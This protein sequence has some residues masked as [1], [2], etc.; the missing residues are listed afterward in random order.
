MRSFFRGAVHARLSP[1]APASA[2]SAAPSCCGAP[3]NVNTFAQVPLLNRSQLVT[4]WRELLPPMRDRRRAPHPARRQAA[5]H[6]P[7]RGRAC[8]R[9]A[10][11]RSSSSRTSAWSPRPR[12]ARCWPSPPIA[13]PASRSP[14][15][16]SA[17]CASRRPLRRGATGA[18]GV[19][20]ARFERSVERRRDSVAHCGEQTT[21]T[22]P[23][24]WY[25]H[26][27]PREL[28]GYVYTDKPIY[29]P[30]HTVHIKAFL[31]WRRTGRCCRSTPRTSSSAS[32]TSPTR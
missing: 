20:N 29:R 27:P 3:I 16:M 22:D 1:G 14:A 17:C 28:V 8:R 10:P 18:D 5:R 12:P 25:L 19:F 31:R 24:S 13:P 26:D 6:L 21:A 4:S 23:G 9:I 32:R 2:R 15:A 11:T 30:G 7:G